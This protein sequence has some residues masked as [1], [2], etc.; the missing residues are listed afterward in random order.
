MGA[1]VPPKHIVGLAQVGKALHGVTGAV[2]RLFPILLPD[3]PGGGIELHL[4]AVFPRPQNARHVK[5][6][7]AVHIFYMAQKHPIEADIRHG[8]HALKTQHLV[9][10]LQN[11]RVRGKNRGIAVIVLH[12]R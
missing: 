8:V 1:P 2:G 3:P 9:G 12:Q 7:G 5:L 6:K 10:A 11:G 4:Q